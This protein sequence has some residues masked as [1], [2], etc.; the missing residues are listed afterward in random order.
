MDRLF[1]V[2]NPEGQYRTKYEPAVYAEILLENLNGFA[3]LAQIRFST[4]PD[5]NELTL[6]SAQWLT[7]RS[8]YVA[9]DQN[10]KRLFFHSMVNE[11]QQWSISKPWD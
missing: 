11:F 8:F 6:E 9:S 3:F 2:K 5:I 10:S 4:S 1:F 7:D